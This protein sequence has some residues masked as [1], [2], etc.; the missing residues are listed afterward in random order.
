[1]KG[2]YKEAKNMHNE[3]LSPTRKSYQHIQWLTLSKYATMQIYIRVGNI[4]IAKIHE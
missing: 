2:I 1:M 4:T 3:A